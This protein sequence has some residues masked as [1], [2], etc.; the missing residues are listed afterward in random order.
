MSDKESDISTLYTYREQM[1]LDSMFPAI[2]WTSYN[3]ESFFFGKRFDSPFQ[4][5]N[6]LWYARRFIPTDLLSVYSI[7]IDKNTVFPTKSDSVLDDML[8]HSNP[9]IFRHSMMRDN[10]YITNLLDPFR[11]VILDNATRP[12]IILPLP[13]WNH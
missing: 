4:S 12:N 8:P 11:I 3:N 13:P 1:I 6:G 9:W 7:E 2:E 10:N 5:N